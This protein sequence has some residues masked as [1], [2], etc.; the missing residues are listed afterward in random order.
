MEISRKSCAR[1][2]VVAGLAALALL[3]NPALSSATV[4]GYMQAFKMPGGTIKVE[5]TG[6]SSPTLVGCQV[7]VAETFGR[8]VHRGEVVLTGSPGAGTYT[9]PP[10]NTAWGYRVSA[11]CID[12]DGE[13]VLPPSPD[14]PQ[15]GSA[16]SADIGLQT[17][18]FLFAS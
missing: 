14:T 4:D 3:A 16:G 5:L 1:G 7:V 18:G 9:T 13:T 17:L 11:T 12:A 8:D 2:G 15:L 10:L 6:I